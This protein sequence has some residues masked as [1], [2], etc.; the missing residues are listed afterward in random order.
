MII[1]QRESVSVWRAGL[2]PFWAILASMILCAFLISWAG[3]SIPEAYGLLVKGA[4]GSSFA[5][6]ET[7]TR[8]IPLILTGLAVSVAFLAYTKTPPQGISVFETTVNLPAAND[9]DQMHV[10]ATG[11]NLRLI[12]PVICVISLINRI[13]MTKNSQNV[14]SKRT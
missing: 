1:E 9:K 8:S 4:F 3:A 12:T 5:I 2:A 14:K 11:T 10:N 7:L 13:K 6:N